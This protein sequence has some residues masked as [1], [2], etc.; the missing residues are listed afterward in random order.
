MERLIKQTAL[1]LQTNPLLPQILKPPAKP[2]ADP[3]ATL[4]ALGYSADPSK[5][6]PDRQ[7]ELSNRSGLRRRNTASGLA[8]ASDLE[9]DLKPTLDDLYGKE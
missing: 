4:A 3:E 5:L 9:T 6:S 8:S 2:P 7:A 1:N